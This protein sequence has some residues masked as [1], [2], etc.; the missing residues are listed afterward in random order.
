MA[1]EALRVQER[2]DGLK[3]KQFSVFLENRVGALLEIVKMLNEQ[4]VDVVALTVQD[5]ADSAIVRLIVSDP[6]LVMDVF[7]EHS[8]AYAII[9]MLVIE[10][11]ESAEELGRV[12]ATLLQAEVNIHF[13]YPLLTRPRGKAALAIHVDDDECAVTVLEGCGFSFLAQNDISR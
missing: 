2:L 7:E 12:L 8:V 10:L 13:S 9:G 3:V 5:S 11:P 6:D 1:L 4:N